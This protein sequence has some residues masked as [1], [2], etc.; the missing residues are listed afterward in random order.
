MLAAPSPPS[1]A[2][3]ASPPQQWHEW[4]HR[5]QRSSERVLSPLWEQHTSKV[6]GYS[7]LPM[8]TI[9]EARAWSASQS[10]LASGQVRD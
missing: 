10:S 8:F 1:P 9:R 7:L 6:S 2:L 3:A 4:P 5:E